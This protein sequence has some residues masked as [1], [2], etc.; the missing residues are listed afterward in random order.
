MTALIIMFLRLLIVKNHGS[1]DDFEDHFYYFTVDVVETLDNTSLEK[2]TLMTCQVIVA[3]HRSLPEG[4]FENI[5]WNIVFKI[6]V[7]GIIAII[8]DD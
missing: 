5:V 6:V 4:I 1:G 7:Y 8:L 3:L 2:Y